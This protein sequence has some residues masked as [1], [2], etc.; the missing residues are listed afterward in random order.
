MNQRQRTRVV[1]DNMDR[2]DFLRRAGIIGGGVM[3]TPA[4][5]AAC[6]SDATTKSADPKASTGPTTAIAKV[7]GSMRLA[8]W[9]LYLDASDQSPAKSKTLQDFKERSGVALEYKVDVDDNDSFTATVEPNLKK[10]NATGYDVAVLTSWM[11][12][13]WIKNGWTE[14]FDDKLLPNKHNLLARL[15]NV[16]WDP[17]RAHTLPYAEG[18][19]GIAYYRDEA[20]FDI[21]NVSDLLD[22]RLKGKVTILSEVRD[23]VG[24]FM[25]EAGLDPATATVEQAKTA[26]VTIKKA[27]DRGQFRK[28]TGNSYTEDLGSKDAIAAIAWS[29]DVAVLQ[30]QNPDL[31][32]VAPAA[33]QMSF[34]DTMLI[35]KGAKNLAQA[36][37]W[38]NF[39]YD[40]VVSG[41]LFEKIN[42]VSPVQGANAYMTE[43][44]RKNVLIN[45][46][47][48]SKIAEFRDLTE[49]EAADL[50][51]AF[52]KATQL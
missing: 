12:A 32:W 3:L 40:P 45:P 51:G 31:L 23:T 48:S 13:R 34:V 39:L 43:K 21:K 50:E 1:A 28:I 41:P 30:E 33:G 9:P 15:Q 8:T 46:P 35:P 47:A 38:M 5:L 10:G 24:L 26:I 25:L 20:G 49:T 22:P 37:A 19:V 6:S 14:P 17:N 7:G 4:L 16:K 44:A 18:Q 27:R 29:G 52:S 42:Y 11:A 36:H 2:R